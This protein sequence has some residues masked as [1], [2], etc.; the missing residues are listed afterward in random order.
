MTTSTA[1]DSPYTNAAFETFLAGCHGP[2][3]PE[4]DWLGERRREAWRL[5]QQTPWP[6]RSDEEWIRT[7]VRMFHPER[8][9]LPGESDPYTGELPRGEMNLPQV[10]GRLVGVNSHPVLHELAGELQERGVIWQVPS[11]V[12]ADA[13]AWLESQL[14]RRAFDIGY[15]RFAALHAA[16]WSGGAVLYVPR[17]VKIDEPFHLLSTMTDGGI[18]LGHLLV[19][20]EDGAEATLVCETQSL[21]EGDG[22]HCGGVE[23]I[24]GPR[25]CLRFVTYQNWNRRTWHFA[26]QK[27]CVSTD[28]QLEWTVGALGS[29]L[30]KVNQTVELE[31]KGAR[32]QVNGTMFTEGRQH[33]AYHTLQHHRAAHG[34]SDFLYKAALQDESRTVWRGMI[35]VEPEAQ[36]TDGYQRCDNLML[37]HGARADSIPGLEIEADDVRCTH[38]ST[39][40][41]VD[42][43][44]LFYAMARGF[45]KREAVKMIVTGFF[46]HVFDRV[47]V[48]SVRDALASA[49]A[50]RVREYE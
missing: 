42:S 14:M 23:L 33:L 35:R 24:V 1:T 43:E 4:P 11:Q 45:T 13:P 50:A 2:D 7:D 29:R 6:S 40:G 39:T 17:G 27:A 26:H 34:T 48:D 21:G 30:A 47:S 38:G 19:I 3:S 41:M 25:A 44:M 20:L 22:F 15:D 18:D 8:Y 16:C 46:Q 10:A 28:G 49:I 31:G 37:S 5:F 36:R 12:A 9:G 32:C